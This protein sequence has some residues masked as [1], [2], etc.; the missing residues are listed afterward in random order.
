MRQPTELGTETSFDA[1]FLIHRLW[2]H[3]NV[4]VVGAGE[5]FSQGKALTYRW[6]ICFLSLGSAKGH[7]HRSEM[8][9]PAQG[10][11]VISIRRVPEQLSS[12]SSKQL[13]CRS[14][15]AAMSTL[16][17]GKGQESEKEK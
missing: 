1:V 13:T 12:G 17:L 15:R 7:T 6:A 11:S 8:E 14:G 2:C 4:V 5:Q 10:V 3:I 9:T 16:H